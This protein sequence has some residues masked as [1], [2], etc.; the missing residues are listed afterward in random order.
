[1]NTV[2]ETMLSLEEHAKNCVMQTNNL[3]KNVVLPHTLIYNPE[4]GSLVASIQSELT[5]LEEVFKQLHKLA[6]GRHGHLSTIQVLSAC[7][8]SSLT[9]NYVFCFFCYFVSTLSVIGKTLVLE[10][11]K[12]PFSR[13]TKDRRRCYEQR[14][15]LILM[16]KCSTQL[17]LNV[18]SLSG[19]GGKMG[20]WVGTRLK[21]SNKTV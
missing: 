20:P 3:Q 6:A 13:L 5:E 1:M 18:T 11:W 7:F 15:Y 12:S 21:K 10:H 17:V 19:P 4:A 9:C 14:K 16:R 2:S 8:L